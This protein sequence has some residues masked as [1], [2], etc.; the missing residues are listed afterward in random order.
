MK[1]WLVISV[2]LTFP[3]IIGVEFRG[4][5]NTLIRTDSAS[6]SRLSRDA[7][8]LFFAFFT[9]THHLSHHAKTMKSTSDFYL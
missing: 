8:Q 2:F 1:V 6:T 5:Q 4:I 9:A 7:D 3:H